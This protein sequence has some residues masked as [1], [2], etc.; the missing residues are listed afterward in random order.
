M[1]IAEDLE[2][3]VKRAQSGDSNALETLV[4]HIQDDVYRLAIRILANPEDAS[5]AAQ[6]ILI[7]IITKLS[8]FER[9]SAFR[10]WVYRVAVNYLVNAK[11]ITDRDPGLSFDAFR[12]DLHA[13]LVTDPAPAADDLVL[14]N[15]LRISC[16]MAMLLC[17]DM[18]HR[19]AYVLGDIFELEHGEAAEILDV[20]KANFRKRL[21]RARAQVV[22]FTSAQCGLANPGA[23]CSCPRRLPAAIK[24]G[25]V[26][27]ERPRIPAGG[28]PGYD[29]ILALANSLKGELKALKLQRA[30]P[31]FQMPD[32]FSA[33]LAR[34]IAASAR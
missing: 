28:A 3:V 24:A 23:K 1:T 4:R 17:L 5:E 16:T 11:K 30:M 10:T 7:L 33:I 34:L 18:K 31:A 8:T 6:E 9:R 12:E 13:G 14:L 2:A 19:L 29:E 27:P 20:S 25:R 32:D 21:S 26:V 22:E 15:E